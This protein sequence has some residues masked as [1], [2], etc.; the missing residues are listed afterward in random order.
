MNRFRSRGS[1]VYNHAGRPGAAMRSARVVA[2]DPA[3]RADTCLGDSKT[4][5]LPSAARRAC[6]RDPTMVAAHDLADER[7][8]GNRGVSDP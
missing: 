4:V 6:A 7:V 3:P 2:T 5:R 1:R 8:T